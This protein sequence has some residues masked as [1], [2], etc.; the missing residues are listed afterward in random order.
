MVSLR[1]FGGVGEIGGNKILLEDGDTRVFLDFGQPFSMGEKFY[2][3]WLSPRRINGLGDY[4]E[5]DLLPKLRGLYAE[6]QLQGTDLDYIEPEYDAVFLSHA[7]FDH[8]EHIKFLDPNIPVYLGAGT[9]LF[10]E[11]MEETSGFT[12]YGEHPYHLFRTG[13][14]IKLGSLE[15]EPVH[16]DHLIPAA[17][18]F[19]IHTSSGSI[20]Y[21][22]DLRGHGPRSDLTDDFLQRAE[23]AEPVALV[24]E[25][26]RI[27]EEESQQSYSE[28]QVK[29]KSADV[30]SET[31]RFVMVTHYSRDMDR[32]RTF[33]QV[34]RE[35]GRKLVISPKTA[36]LLERLMDDERLNLPDP[37]KDEGI[38]VYYR[39]KKTGTFQGS[40]YY[41]WERRFMDKLVDHGYVHENQGSLLMN[42]DFYQFTELIDIRPDAGSPFIHSMSEP[43]SE[44]DLEDRVMRNWLDHFG[45]RYHQLH[46]SGHMG[47]K[48]LTEAIEAINPRRL[49]PVHTENP[50]L[51]MRL[52]DSAV[53]P[54]KSK[55]YML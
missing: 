5:F 52:F 38:L 54:E 37:L 29:E 45:L 24:T 27:D 6:E 9:R 39:R 7:H 14:K 47:R 3:S 11:A 41:V 15:V 13:D 50:Q 33:Y 53:T 26:T 18:G 34:A 32:L 30:V 36:Y 22:G 16:V 25:G 46:A 35:N 49:F 51:F 31:D 23:E 55:E 4:F 40:D 42:L 20:V 2:T 21:T 8:V 44:E 17:Y 28:M 12:D 43:R 19:I 48:E 1:F 10:M